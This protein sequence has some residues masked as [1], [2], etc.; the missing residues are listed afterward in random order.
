MSYKKRLLTKTDLIKNP[1]NKHSDDNNVSNS[2]SDSQTNNPE[3]TSKLDEYKPP[4]LPANEYSSFDEQLGKPPLENH[5]NTKSD[6]ESINQTKD[7]SVTVPMSEYVKND[8][9]SNEDVQHSTESEEDTSNLETWF[10][11]T[12]DNTWFNY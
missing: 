12:N 8:I 2:S 6:E 7:K 10:L 4:G 3:L 5:D 11:P 9:N 1:V